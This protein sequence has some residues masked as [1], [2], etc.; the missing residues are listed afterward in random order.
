MLATPLMLSDADTRLAMTPSD[1]ELRRR[2]MEA[3]ARIREG[4][5]SKEKV[6]S[7]CHKVARKRG[8]RAADQLRQD[9]REQWKTRP[10]WMTEG[11]G[12]PAD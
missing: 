10:Q 9:M 6:D 3:R 12:P 1:I 4:F 5:D 2:I 11:T 8:Q 7:L